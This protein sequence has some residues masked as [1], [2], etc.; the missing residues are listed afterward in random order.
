MKKNRN[1][2]GMFDL[3]RGI[4]MIAVVMAHSI[5]AHVKYWEPE[6]TQ[7][8]WYCFLIFFKPV[9]YGLIPMFFIMSGYGF[10]KK[11]VRKC[12]KDRMKYVL[13]PYIF[14]AVIVTAIVVMRKLISHGSIRD[15]LWYN[16]APFI[17]GL[18]P[19]EMWLGGHYVGSVGPIWFLVVLVV[20]W[21][22][23]DIIFMLESEFIRALCIVT[24]TVICTHLQFMSFI[25]FCWIQSLCCMGYIYIGYM[26]K[27][28]KV[29]NEKL[30][31][32]NL[33]M[34]L[35]ISGCIM[36]LGNVDV[37]QNVWQQGFLDY[38]SSAIAGVLFIKLFLCFNKF[39]GRISNGIRYIGKYSLYILCIHTIE[40][41][42]FPWEK[43]VDIFEN[44][45]FIGVIVS[46]VGR[47]VFIAAGCFIVT[48]YIQITKKIKK[49]RLS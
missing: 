43:V 19:G 17:I 25:P 1:S 7:Q 9:I 23:L 26:L 22:M 44:H 47:A 30:S 14:T 24:L 2:L 29:L 41:L 33:I 8:W 49:Q 20:G 28:N 35:I 45:K 36:L 4:L 6:Y 15:A 16:L 37:S 48:K 10:K 38:I 31:K 32:Q 27:K 39:N 21:I 46:F 13:K 5:T 11:P 40:Y 34:L 18:C 42:A 3:S 12:I